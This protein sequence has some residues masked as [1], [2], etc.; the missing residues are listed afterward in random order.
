MLSSKP[1][2]KVSTVWTPDF[3][4]RFAA[5]MEF[6]QSFRTEGV[7]DGKYPLSD[8]MFFLVQRYCTRKDADARYEMHRR[9]ADI[10][11]LVSGRE[12]LLQTFGP[13]PEIEAFDKKADIGFYGD[14][15][16]ETVV[17]L[18]AGAFAL[19]LPGEYHKPSLWYDGVRGDEV[20][21][22]VVKIPVEENCR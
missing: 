11:Y 20:V 17:L 15:E 22:L 2:I 12:R 4:R 18:R 3:C 5:A 8:G 1:E 7:P 19:Y 21:K 6:L 10:Q 16:P 13:L 14:G 9:Y